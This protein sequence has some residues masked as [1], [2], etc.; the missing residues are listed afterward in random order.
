VKLWWVQKTLGAVVIGAEV[1]GADVVGAAVMGDAV[2]GTGVK[3]GADAI[4][5]VVSVTA[6]SFAFSFARATNLVRLP[7]NS[8][9]PELTSN[10]RFLCDGGLG[11]SRKP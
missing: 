7:S 9:P 1:V 5:A 6:V 8:T 4:G 3:L 10:P 2:T 11:L